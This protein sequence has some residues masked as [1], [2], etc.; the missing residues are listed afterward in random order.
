[1]KMMQTIKGNLFE[2]LCCPSLAGLLEMT[3]FLRVEAETLRH[4]AG[5]YFCS[6]IEDLANGASQ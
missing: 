3:T 2:L 5:C 4:H 6:A 1:M